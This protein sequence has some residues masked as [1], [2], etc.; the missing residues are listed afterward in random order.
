MSFTVL[1]DVRRLGCGSHS[2]CYGS[3]HDDESDCRPHRPP[4]SGAAHR[5]VRGAHPDRGLSARPDAIANFEVALER[6][7]RADYPS[8]EDAMIR[9]EYGYA[10]RSPRPADPPPIGKLIERFERLRAEDR[11]PLDAVRAAIV[12]DRR[13]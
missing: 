13:Q 8:G 5:S 4:Q 6:L 12:A 10:P 7:E 11:A 2:L 1:G 9:G 3:R